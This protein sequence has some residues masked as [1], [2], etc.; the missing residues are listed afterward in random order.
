MMPVCFSAQCKNRD[1][2]ERDMKNRKRDERE[3]SGQGGQMAAADGREEPESGGGGGGG[4]DLQVFWK[5]WTCMSSSG[6][7]CLK[8]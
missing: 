2:S 5:V 3:A 4:G 7:D 1:L 6:K 8:L